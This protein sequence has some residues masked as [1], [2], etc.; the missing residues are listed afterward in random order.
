MSD[1]EPDDTETELLNRAWPDGIPDAETRLLRSLTAQRRSKV[2]ARL[3][4]LLE[5]EDARRTNPNAHVD[6]RAKAT[7]AGVTTDGL[8]AIRRKWEASRSL[9]SIA[10]YLGRAERQPTQRDEDDPVVVAARA[11]IATMADSPDSV[12]ASRLRQEFK[13]AIPNMIRLVRRLRRDDATDPDRI[14]GT[15]G[16]SLLVDLSAIDRVTIGPPAVPIVC[17]VVIE[18]ASGLILGSA[19]EESGGDTIAAQTA[20]V[21]GAI[22]FVSRHALDVAGDIA[23]VELTVGD[24]PDADRAFATAGRMKLEGVDLRVNSSGPRRYGQRLVSQLGKRLGRL[25]WRPR[26]TAP[27]SEPSKAD[28]NNAIAVADAAVLIAGEVEEH[29]GEILA[30]LAEGGIVPGWGNAD[31]AMI[32]AL[33]RVLAVLGQGVVADGAEDR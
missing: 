12:L 10:P 17:A 14:G 20:A 22:A 32:A 19:V 6:L 33:K 28:R 15:F 2:I 24:G 18:R 4:A 29:N 7:A 1:A 13:T 3:R 9:A 26:F 8:F 16:R 21:R 27:G 11:L 25:W 5:I 31:G 30:A 23:A